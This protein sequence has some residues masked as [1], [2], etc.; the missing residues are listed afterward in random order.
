MRHSSVP[1]IQSVPLARTRRQ[2]SRVGRIEL[3]DGFLRLHDENLLLKEFAQKQEDRIKRLGT[4][5]S[6]LNHERARAGGRPG[7][8]IRSSSRNLDLEE[9]LEDTQE[10]VRELERRNEGL[11]NRLHFYKQQLQLQGCGR[12]C[13]YGY[14]SPRV[15][16]GLRRMHTTAGRVPERLRKGM[17][18][19]GP[20]VR[21]THTAPPR[22]GDRIAESSGAETERL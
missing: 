9:D 6:R 16:T 12:H 1:Q 13:P 19:Q 10:R 7:T 15:D 18:V 14:V 20:E 17:R 21:S 4:K 2:V 11:R 3:E 8:W 22:Y 5:L